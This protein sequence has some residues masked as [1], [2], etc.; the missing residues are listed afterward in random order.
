MLFNFKVLGYSIEEHDIMSKF[1]LIIISIFS[2]LALVL[3]YYITKSPIVLV[4]KV[5]L[6]PAVQAVYATGTVEASVM[7]PL[8]SRASAKLIKLNVDEGNVVSKGQLL[9]EL[10]SEDMKNL[11]NE[12]LV[13]ESY[14]KSEYERNLVAN[15]RGAISPQILNKVKADWQMLNASVEKAKADINYLK[16]FA[17][18]DG[19]II[20]RD[21]EIGQLIPANQTIF[22]FKGNQPLRITSEVD[23][24]DIADIKVD[25]PVLIQTDAFPNQ[26]F[27][28]KVKSITPK[29]DPV[30][31]SY[32]VRIEFSEETPLKIGM[33]AET[34]IIIKQTENAVLVP[35]SSLLENKVWLVKEGR[36]SEKKVQVGT[37]GIDKIEILEGISLS[38]NVV[39]TP[40]E[41]FT[42]GDSVESK[43]VQ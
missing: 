24:E 38:D 6:G 36:L 12:L 42:E 30:A 2:I 3:I 19:T 33:T 15:N 25:Q 1:S 23:E 43:E 17:P 14:A 41:N 4:T 39:I 20:K 16:I 21:G 8:A 37:R 40:Q 27:H 10:E 34:N 9:A 5:K 28:G 35:A 31:R 7:L 18:E 22:W 13:K 29:G 26:Q 11:L 32:R